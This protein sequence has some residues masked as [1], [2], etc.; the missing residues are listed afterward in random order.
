M[1]NCRTGRSANFLKRRMKEEAPYLLA[2]NVNKLLSRSDERRIFP[3]AARP[4][5][6][7]L[8][9]VA[10]RTSGRR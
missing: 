3:N 6:V 7:L 10:A 1:P 2:Q 9:V 8:I 5:V 4:K